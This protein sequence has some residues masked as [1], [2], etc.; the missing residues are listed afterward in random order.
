VLLGGY[1]AEQ[2]VLGEASS[3]A[4]QDLRQATEVAYDMVAHYGMSDRVG[5]VFY[6]HHVEHPFLGQRL[7]SDSTLGDAA[8]NLVDAEVQRALAAAASEARAVVEQHR[9]ML[10]RLVE[11]LVEHETVDQEELG[12]LLSA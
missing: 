2:A 8:S 1:A 3:G 9:P 12:R 6:E 4:E 10:D 11:A 7:A 5:P